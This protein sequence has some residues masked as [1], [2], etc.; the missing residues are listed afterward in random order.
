VNHDV[1][2]VEDAV[3]SPAAGFPLRYNKAFKDEVRLWRIAYVRLWRSNAEDV[4]S[5][6]FLQGK[7]QN[8]FFTGGGCHS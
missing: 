1:A 8:D 7:Q 4:V 2:K 6:A 5:S 3:A